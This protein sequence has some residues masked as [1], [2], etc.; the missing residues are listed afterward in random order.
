MHWSATQLVYA[1]LPTHT[2]ITTLFGH[3]NLPNIICE[4]ILTLE[5]HKKFLKH[6]PSSSL[7]TAKV[8]L[9]IQAVVLKKHGKTLLV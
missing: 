3:T 9:G 1:L 6:H 5:G 2:D 8:M 4:C 7:G